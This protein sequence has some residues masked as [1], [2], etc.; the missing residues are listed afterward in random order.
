MGNKEP[1][2]NI[3]LEPGAEPV[4]TE[5]LRLLPLSQMFSRVPKIYEVNEN[6]RPNNP[7][8]SPDILDVAP[9]LSSG[10]EGLQVYEQKYKN[11]NGPDYVRKVGSAKLNEM[12][13]NDITNELFNEIGDFNMFSEEVPNHSKKTKIPY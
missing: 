5:L 12:D 7:V 6:A 9:E 3:E 1:L 4:L 8:D 11:V 10:S 13:G 2:P